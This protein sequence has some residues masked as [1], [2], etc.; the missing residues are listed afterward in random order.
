MS[1]EVLWAV[2]FTGADGVRLANSAD[3]AV[4]ETGRIFGCDTWMCELP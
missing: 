4:L 3:V 1:I 2:Q